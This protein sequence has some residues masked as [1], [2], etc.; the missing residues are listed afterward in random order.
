MDNFIIRRKRMRDVKNAGGRARTMAL[1]GS[2]KSIMI[3]HPDTTSTSPPHA[4]PHLRS[5]NAPVEKKNHPLTHTS[6]FLQANNA[7]TAR[8]S[9]AAP[10]RSR[11][12]PAPRTRA[13]RSKRAPSPSGVSLVVLWV[14]PVHYTFCFVSGASEWSMVEVG[15]TGWIGSVMG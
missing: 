13:R 6:S 8:R 5:R 3:L 9:S 4:T 14:R 11:V 10:P 1:R 2:C 7:R 12:A 15:K